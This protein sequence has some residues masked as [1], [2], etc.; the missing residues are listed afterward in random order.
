MR[1]TRILVFI[2]LAAL[3]LSCRNVENDI[4]FKV[5]TEDGNFNFG[6]DGGNRKIRVNAGDSWV[7]SSGD[8]WITVSPA[9]GKG[10]AECTVRVD[11]SLTLEP[12]TGKVRITKGDES[13]IIEI[14]Q[15]GYKRELVVKEPEV[16]LKNYAKDKERFFDVEVKSNS[17]VKVQITY[18]TTTDNPTTDWLKYKKVTPDFNRGERPRNIRLRFEWDVNSR[19]YDRDATI[20]FVPEKELSE[21]AKNDVVTVKQ[22]AADKIE[23]N[24]SGD[25][26]ALI[27]ISRA[28]NLMTPWDYSTPMDNWTG[29]RLWEEEHLDEIK[30][31]VDGDPSIDPDDVEDM[32]AL[33]RS[34]IGRVRYVNFFMFDTK[35]E[36]PFEVQYLRAAEEVIFYSNVNTFLKSLS[37]GEYIGALTQLKRL[38]VAA[39][40]LTSVDEK[41]FA[42]LK[43]LEYLDLSGNNFQRLPDVINP[44]TYPELH[45]LVLLAN[46]RNAIYDLSNTTKTDYGGFTE[47]SPFLERLLTWDNLDTLR[48]SVNY[49][50][51]NL[52]DCSNYPKYTQADIDN[53]QAEAARHGL[54]TVKADFLNYDIPKVLPNIKALAVNY[55]RLHGE[56]PKWI[57]YH[58]KLD[59]WDPYTF[60][61]SQEG[62]A[63]PPAGTG[64]GVKAGFSNEPISLSNYGSNVNDKNMIVVDG[65]VKSYYDI[66]PYK[67]TN[68]YTKKK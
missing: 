33:Y 55:N 34:Y 46:Q 7:A 26:L 59:L 12:R 57:L 2:A 11:S 40:G 6:P 45:S 49:L 54:D 63:P 9:N 47:D 3:S 16:S 22:T 43:N 65:K 48:L 67:L 66:H 68:D 24:R 51:G 18:N 15:E 1:T 29:V 28:I 35:N 53:A 50:H 8:T 5:D 25:S 44:T 56:L 10:S 41:A 42:K 19:Q 58:P 31:L 17:D 61:F 21:G 14:S 4:A 27:A 38:T 64:K 62:I 30:D 36:L 32:D 60:I 37:T 20:A 23:N 52:P 13:E 39:Y